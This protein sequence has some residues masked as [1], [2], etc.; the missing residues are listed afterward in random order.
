MRDLKLGTVQSLQWK[1]L[2]VQPKFAKNHPV[3]FA[4]EGFAVAGATSDT[5]V[6]V[7]KTECGDQLL[8][9]NH[10]G[11]YA[12]IGRIVLIKAL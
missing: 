12:H 11:E 7:C 6:L 9:L 3:C 5:K 10:S 8:L 2:T 1:A 4:H